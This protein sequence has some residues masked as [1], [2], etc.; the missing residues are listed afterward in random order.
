MSGRLTLGI[1][2]HERVA[3][4]MAGPA[5]RCWEFAK[6]LAPDA[7]VRLFTPE[8]SD[9]EA[10]GFELVTYD[11]NDPEGLAASARECDVLLAQGFTFNENPALTQM[12]K[13]LVID[14]YVPMTLEA[15]GQYEHLPLNEQSGIQ[16]GIVVALR[17]QMEIGHFYI[18]ASERQRDYWLGWLSMAG[19]V[20]PGNYRSDRTLRELI[21]V[22]PFGL[23]DSPPAATGKVL[24]GVHPA[25]GEDDKVLLW[26]GGIYNWLDPFTPIRAVAALSH[27]RDDIKLFFLGARHP[28]PNVPRM[29][30]YDEAVSLSRE[31]GVL[32]RSVIFNDT[33]VPYAERVDYLLEADLGVNANVEHIETRFSFRTR[34]L[35]C[36]WASLPLVSTDG[37]S[38]SEL[39]DLRGLGLVVAS[40]DEAAYADAIERLID[41]DRLYESCRGNIE[42]VAREF[43]WSETT[44]PLK[45]CLERFAATGVSP[46]TSASANSKSP[47]A[48]N[49]IDRLNID[50]AA[51]GSKNEI[52][53]GSIEDST[54]YRTGR[55][56]R[57]A[58]GKVKRKIK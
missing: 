56:L 8:E 5:I 7:D 20:T 26:G 2:S 45:H 32:D 3:A 43:R 37:D 44:R 9:L 17:K 40:G 27:K 41:D 39:A 51:E 31:L 36:I 24:K 34:I 16:Q 28:N 18:C 22:V 12:G 29:R 35:D 30:V 13:F 33:W 4:S 10:S 47:V 48:A 25:V 52:T 58:A 21:G 55:K 49:A 42:S 19:R 1:I 54:V 53:V 15:M 14:L 50:S 11:R 57:R 38:L 46:G 23:P 6:A